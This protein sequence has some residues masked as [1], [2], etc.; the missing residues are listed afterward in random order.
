MVNGTTRS[1]RGIAASPPTSQVIIRWTLR[2]RPGEY[3][4]DGRRVYTWDPDARAG[5]MTSTNRRA[6]HRYVGYQVY[7]S[8]LVQEFHWTGDPSSTAGLRAPIPPYVVACITTPSG[9]VRGKVG[10]RLVELSRELTPDIKDVVADRGFSTHKTTFNRV[11]HEMGLNL[12]H[13]HTSTQL[14]QGRAVISKSGDVVYFHAGTPFHISMPDKF[15]VIT[16]RPELIRCR[17][18]ES[19]PSSEDECPGHPNAV[20]RD[21]EFR[22]EVHLLTRHD[23][24]RDGSIRFRCN[25]CSPQ[26]KAKNAQLSPESQWKEGAQYVPAPPGLERCCNGNGFI[27]VPL[28]QLDD[29][30]A[31]PLLTR[32]HRSSYHRRLVV[33]T[34]IGDLREYLGR[35]DPYTLLFGIGAMTLFSIAACVLYNLELERDRRPASGPEVSQDSAKSD[36][37]DDTEL[38]SSCCELMGQQGDDVVAVDSLGVFEEVAATESP[39]D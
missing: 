36:E 24:Q 17:D 34:V 37:P 39:P 15:R 29:Y 27:R 6:A 13:D 14:K 32:A 10:A 19:C 5:W 16:G 30:Q 9:S 12:T 38:A 4:R 2:P 31:V 22:A 21:A 7:V 1:D 35:E 28:D 26:G 33:E 11:L 8:S 3:D 25:F 18:G 23:R 20:M